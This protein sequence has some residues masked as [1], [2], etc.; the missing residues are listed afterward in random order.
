[1]IKQPVI[2]ASQSPRRQ[3]LIRLFCENVDVCPSQ[4][5]EIIPEK[6][7]PYPDKVSMHLAKIKAK[8]LANK[9]P[10]RVI[11][12]ADTVV[13][14]DGQILGK[15]KDPADARRMLSLLSGKTHV[16][17]T[18]VCILNGGQE[19]CFCDGTAVS[20]YPLSEQEIASY[21]ASGEPFDKAGAYGIQGK[22]ATL[23]TGIDG[24]YFSVVGLPVS[25]LY[26]MLDELGQL[27]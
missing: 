15:P 18:G 7:L 11:I 13:S 8:D 5:E 17:Y 27:E 19:D 2:L 6:L 24:D 1:M 22:G 26:T 16:V 4:A 10:D 12:G 21:I 3:E 14:I 20:F 23:I 9:Y 25:M